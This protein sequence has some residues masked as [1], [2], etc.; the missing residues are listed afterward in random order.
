MSHL[1]PAGGSRKPRRDW[2]GRDLIL[3]RRRVRTLC[4]LRGR[5]QAIVCKSERTPKCWGQRVNS[6]ER[7]GENVAS[8][9]YRRGIRKGVL[10]PPRH[11]AVADPS[12]CPQEW[13]ESGFARG[14]CERDP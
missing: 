3:P 13:V 1:A 12:W 14:A 4:R 7:I 8:I 10:L 9:G 2:S 11:A 6:G 5:R